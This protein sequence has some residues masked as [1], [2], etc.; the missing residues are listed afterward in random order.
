MIR[1]SALIPL[2]AALA[3]CSST[4]PPAP[5]A[6]APAAVPAPR[7]RAQAAA[8]EFSTTLKAALSAQMAQGGTVAAIGFCHEE[9]PKIAAHVGATHGVRLGRV[10]VDG[11]TR[12]PANAASAW[13]AEGLAAFKA[14]VAAGTPPAELV[15]VAEAGLP[16]GVAVR[17]M[18]GI[19]VEPVCLAC[20]GKALSP[21]TATALRR[22]YPDDAATGFDAGDLR[23]ALWVEVPDAP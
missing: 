9:A 4:P 21:E 10:A 16:D 3:A 5:A 12:N 15:R 14:Q 20:H 17:M 6:T 23:G 19:A 8:K 13:Q 2:L 18:R 7:E 1:A 22:H 11:R